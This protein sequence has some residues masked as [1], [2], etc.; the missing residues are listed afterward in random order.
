MADPTL[1]HVRDT[2]RGA[3]EK[4]GTDTPA[5]LDMAKVMLTGLLPEPE[6]GPVWPRYVHHPENRMP[7]RVAADEEEETKILDEWGVRPTTEPRHAASSSPRASERD[8]R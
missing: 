8:K 7:S 4:M 6:Q 1:E 3:L 2:V 5:D